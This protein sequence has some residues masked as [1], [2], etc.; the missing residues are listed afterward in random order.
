MVRFIVSFRVQNMLTSRG[1][2]RLNM[3]NYL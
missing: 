2:R 3:R 1:N